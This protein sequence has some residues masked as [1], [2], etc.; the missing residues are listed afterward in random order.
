MSKVTF[1]LE[2]GQVEG[3]YLKASEPSAPLVVITNGHNGFYNYGM[4]PHIQKTFQ[5][6]GISSYSYNFSHGGVVADSDYFTELDKYEKN[7]MRLETLDLLGVL[8]HLSDS[9]I[10]FNSGTDLYLFSHSLGVVPTIFAARKFEGR[11]L[12]GIVLLAP[13]KTLNVFPKEMIDKWEENG[14]YYMKNNRTGQEL[15]QGSEFLSEIKKSDSEW[16]L[17]DAI[18]DVGTRYLIV[19]GKEDKDVPAEHSET[20]QDWAEDSGN[21][22]KRHL[23]ENAGHTFNTKHPFEGTTPEL[24]QGLGVVVKW[25]SGSSSL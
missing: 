24:E 5:K 14:V 11:D 20:L 22:V 8:E 12:S 1:E 25:M 13:I 21:D 7:S 10:D 19:H 23:I 18:R 3:I 4:F 2:H 9:V 17:E 16:N 15:P 6:H